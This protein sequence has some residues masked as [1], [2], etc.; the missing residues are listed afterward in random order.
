VKQWHFSFI[1]FFVGSTKIEF[2]VSYYNHFKD[3]QEP[4]GFKISST[5][6]PCVTEPLGS[7]T[8]WKKELELDGEKNFFEKSS[9]FSMTA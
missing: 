9:H 6:H 5:S 7:P 4:G 1:L 2:V 8:R 3:Q